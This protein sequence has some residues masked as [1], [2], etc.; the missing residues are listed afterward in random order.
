[1]FA[2]RIPA[3]MAVSVLALVTSFAASAMTVSPMQVEMTAVG[4][5]ATA[6]VSVVNNSSQALPVE[7]VMARLTLD[8]N[9]KQSTSKAG[10]E[11]LIMPPQAVI[12]PGATQNFRV[13]WLG[14]PMM[15]KSESFMLLINQVPVKLPAK[16]A[17][18]QVVMGLGVMINV[19][20][21]TG[22]P[23]LKVVATGVT[24]DK[25]GRRLPV[26]TVENASNVHALLPQASLQLAGG[27]WSSTLTPAALGDRVGIGLVQPGRRRKFTLPVELPAGIVKFEAKLEMA[28]RR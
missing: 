13:Q 7:A 25:S 11:F 8:E 21:A 18:V 5:R 28:Q 2:L 3:A 16:S 17:G 10:E 23:A 9:G 14:D 27:G 4:A 26:V 6:R 15:S 20:P 24:T 12:P 22:S 19:A 1:M